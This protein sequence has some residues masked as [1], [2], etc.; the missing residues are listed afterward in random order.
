MATDI[1]I[2]GLDG[3]KERLEA[4]RTE[5]PGFQRRLRAAV[6]RIVS[7]ARARLVADAQT[8]LGMQS[9]PR[10]AVQ[11]VRATVYKRILGGNVNIL[12]RRQAGAPGTLA[13]QAKRTG[14]GGNRWGRSARTRQMM[15][16][17]GA[18]R[19]FALRFLNAGTPARAIHSYTSPS[20]GAT[21]SLRSGTGNRGSIVAR[22]WFAA[23]S[24]EELERAAEQLEAVLREV[25]DGNF[26]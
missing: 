4:L 26:Y 13:Q 22:P 8:G 14:R 6:R 3:L 21:H 11:A 7:E 17:R 25:I 24:R 12:S 10:S 23:S 18:D 9:D 19:G 15:A 16:Y 5:S 20:D 1:T 2:E